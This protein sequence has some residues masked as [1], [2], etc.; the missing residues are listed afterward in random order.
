MWLER[1]R[2]LRP[3]IYNANSSLVLPARPTRKES[4][5][6]LEEP[7]AAP[8][9]AHVPI[10]PPTHTRLVHHNLAE[11]EATLE[12]IRNEGIYQ[13]PD[14]NL[15]VE[16]Y[17]TEWYSSKHDSVDS[18][19]GEVPSFIRFDRPGWSI[20]TETRTIL[21]STPE[22]LHVLATLDAWEGER[23]VYSRNWDV[24]ILRDF[25]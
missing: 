20:R 2:R 1:P 22:A 8:L 5:V 25:V 11:G 23:R 9:T 21:T 6:E 4:P 17:T 15:E 3:I 24:T 13:I 10:E 7:E 12:V 16:D 19:R 18:T 14:I